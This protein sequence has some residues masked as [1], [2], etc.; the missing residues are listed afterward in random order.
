MKKVLCPVDLSSRNSRAIEVASA[1]ARDP[2]AELIF[3]HVAVPELPRTAGH[4]IV[5]VNQQIEKERTQ[6]L[7]LRPT[8]PEISCRHETIR[9][10]AAEVIVKFANEN[11][12]D[13]IVMATHGRSGLSRLLLGSVA[14][15]VLRQ[16]I[17]PVLTI[18]AKDDLEHTV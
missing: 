6:L 7:Q 2:G 16:A 4:A 1:L 13:L 8:H 5:E 3:L 9:G 11:Q 15:E 17:C 18:R 10:D 12:V 14:E